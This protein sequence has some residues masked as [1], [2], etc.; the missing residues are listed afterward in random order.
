MGQDDATWDGST[1]EPTEAEALGERS[2]ALGE[3]PSRGTSTDPASVACLAEHERYED[4]GLLG[5]GGMGEVHQVRD[6]R[7]QRVMAMKR[8]HPRATSGSIA[9]F[10]EEAQATA[11]LQHPGIVPV[12][13]LG[14][15]ADGTLFFTMKQVKGRTLAQALRDDDT[16]GERRLR[17]FV[18][19]VQRVAEAMAYAH[20]RGVIHRDLKPANV[21]L[22]DFGEVLVVD[23]GLAKVLGPEGAVREVAPDDD[24]DGDVTTT[25]SASGGFRTRVG[26]VSGTPSYMAPEQARGDLEAIGRGTDVYALGA[27]LYEVLSGRAPYRGR[28]GEVLQAVLRG[29]PPAPGGD[30]ALEAL[31]VEAMARQP[32][33]RPTA[34]DL[35]DALSGWLDGAQ[36]RARAE[37]RMA[38]CEEQWPVVEQLRAD[39]DD[40]QSRADE[41]LAD[42]PAY[43]SVDRKRAAWQLLD[44]AAGRRREADRLEVDLLQQAQNAL[45]EAPGLP[46]A[47][48]LLARYHRARHEAAE[49]RRDRHEALR[50]EQY[51]RIHD[52]GE[53]AAYLDGTG[54]LTLHT[55]PAATV[56][57]FRYERV[58]RRRVPQ[59]ARMLG[60]TPLVDEPLAHG[61]Y[62]L[63]L[64]APGCAR[65]RYP[66]A[67]GRTEAWHGVPP[68]GSEPAVVVLP[69]ADQL[70]E[71]R[72]VFVAGGW[73]H[74]G[75]D[76]RACHSPPPLRLWVDAFVIQRFAVTNRDYLTFLDALVEAGRVDDAMSHVP[77]VAGT[78][79]LL[80]R[81][82]DDGRFELTPDPDGDDW[83]LAWPVMHVSWHDA[84]A[85]ASWF[86]EHTG[87]GWR[88]P[89]EWEWEKAARGVDARFYAWGD[90]LDPS[91]ACM[92][93]S[94]RDDNVLPAPVT[95]FAADESPYGVRGTVGGMRDWVAERYRRDGQLQLDGVRPEL[96]VADDTPGVLRVNRGGSW[97]SREDNT[98]LASRHWY[99]STSCESHVGFRLARSMAPISR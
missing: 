60:R 85:Y 78:E 50:E 45:A 52:Q 23:W 15:A 33:A 48:R 83:D 24:D 10:V 2:P 56:D 93:E 74:A 16:P 25:R 19:V 42:L 73:F 61:S 20:A 84:R 8:L 95:A 36:R 72:E 75:G 5:R 96:E 21:M 39:A 12:H 66:V 26:T 62:L 64:S 35:A 18:G 81:R 77:R 7:L 4:L 65:V 99:P 97:N 53:H 31:C 29:P 46:S 89:S 69:R 40:L 49:R 47:H 76:D 22:G 11:Q 88:L 98:R 51:L 44:A 92:V 67:I 13:D 28:S 79:H 32:I 1:L 55:E 3:L 38:E 41:R 9:R 87:Q 80:Y 70:D 54:R 91:W 17:R 34:A 68:G 90:H 27:L 63:E 57:L 6:L 14:M 94:H 30:E 37:R 71:E 59:F 43:A 58:D 86:A 82:R